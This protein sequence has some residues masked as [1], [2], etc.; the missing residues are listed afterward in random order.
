MTNIMINKI[1]ST[2]TFLLL[3]SGCGIEYRENPVCKELNYMTF[4]EFRA[5]GIEIL[6]SQEIE[7]AEKIYVY[8]NT[9]L[10]TEKDKGVH[11]IDNSD[12]QNPLPKAFLKVLGNKDISVKKGYLYLDSYMDLL[13]IDIR[14]LNKIKV[15]NRI[16]NTFTYDPK[17]DYYECEFDT[18]KGV[19]V[20]GNQWEN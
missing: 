14:D 18:S 13:V 20:G 15:V 9:L 12:K 10:V 5:K 17:E 7:K 11:I 2:S 16:N 6:P 19:I 8:K 3:L 4:E 1:V